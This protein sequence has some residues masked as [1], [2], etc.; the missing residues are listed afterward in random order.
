V[1]TSEQLPV[2]GDHVRVRRGV[3]QAPTCD[4]LPHSPDEQGHTGKVV[5]VRAQPGAPHH[6]YLV[7][8]DRPYPE[9]AWDGIP[10]PI[11][12]RHYAADELEVISR[13]PDR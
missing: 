3:G 6:P 1:D 12:V 4:E 7:M 9:T 2:V 8:L 10:M 5:A 11:A 13:E